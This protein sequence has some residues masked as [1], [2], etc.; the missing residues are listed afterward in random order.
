MAQSTLTKLALTLTL[1]VS[2]LTLAQ[3][4]AASVFPDISTIQAYAETSTSYPVIINDTQLKEL[5]GSGAKLIDVRPAA[6]YEKGHIHN[7]INLPWA[8]LNVSERAGIR[9]ELADDAVFEQILSDAGLSL[10]DT[11]LI[12]DTSSLPGRA[13]VALE[14]A[15]FTKIHVLDGGIAAYQGDLTTEPTKVIAS[16]FKLE[17]KHDI[18]VDKAY[19][20]QKLNAP[21][22]VIVDGRNYDAY[23]DGHI[24]GAKSLS[25]NQLLT[26]SRSLQSTDK[27]NS[28]LSSRGI[29]KDKEII[30]YCG[31]GVAAANNYVALKNLGY[32]NVVLYDASW[33]EWSISS[34]A[35][36]SVALGNYTFSGGNA[37][38]DTNDAPKFLTAEEVKE[39]GAKPDTVVLDVRSPSDYGAGQ[40]PGSVN[41]FWNTTLDDQRVLKSPEEL[42]Q[43]YT[44]A[45]VTPD[46][47]VIIFT[48]GGLQLSHSYTVLALLG[49]KDINFFTGKFEGW[50]NGAMK[51]G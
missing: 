11:L 16:D 36:Q 43:L 28:L 30:A 6:A 13:F 22:S 40:I 2:A 26:E 39:L 46:K 38:L 35:A 10:N 19:V 49:F 48:R 20:D 18:R 51:Q 42:K 45:G 29:D 23:A 17:N 33:D 5:V 50:E 31:S 15:G 41:I 25:P 1:T 47:K 24:P 14:Y 34:N 21:E 8:K 3:P 32:E 9:N 7:A 4:F 27:L 37:E 12:Y 44:A